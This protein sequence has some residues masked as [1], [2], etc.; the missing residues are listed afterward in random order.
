MTQID[1]AKNHGKIIHEGVLEDLLKEV[2][3]LE[4]KVRKLEGDNI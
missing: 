3:L 4:D 1:W 2:S